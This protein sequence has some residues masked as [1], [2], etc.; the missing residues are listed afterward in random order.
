MAL[1]FSPSR[2]VTG[3][4]AGWPSRGWKK[5]ASCSS[6]WGHCASARHRKSGP[7]I[8]INII[9]EHPRLKLGLQLLHTAPRPLPRHRAALLPRSRPQFSLRR[10]PPPPPP[11]STI[12]QPSSFNPSPKYPPPTCSKSR[13]SPST[14]LDLPP[15]CPLSLLTCPVRLAEKP[16]LNV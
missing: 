5:A 10:K 9:Y 4:P 16:E 14:D 2:P 7:R 13:T 11:T 15:R 1:I 3:A 8:L 6:N 12:A